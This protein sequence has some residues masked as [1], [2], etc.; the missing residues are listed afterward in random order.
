MSER[1]ELHSFDEKIDPKGGGLTTIV[2]LLVSLGFLLAA[3]ASAGSAL[4]QSE[5]PDGPVYIVQPGDT[6]YTIALRFGVTVEDL[7]EANDLSPDDLIFVGDRILIPG[8][9]GMTGVLDTVTVPFGESLRSL[10]RRHQIPLDKLIKL[11]R[12]TSPGELYAGA[13]LVLP[14]TAGEQIQ[15]TRT[16]LGSGQTALELAVLENVNPWELAAFNGLSNPARALPGDV[17]FVPNR[18]PDGPGGF[19]APVTEVQISDAYQG[20]TFTA[21]IQAGEG[22][23]F[24][25]TLGPYEFDFF[26]DGQGGYFAL[27]GIHPLFEPG[28]VPL[29]ISG[30]LANG[31]RFAHTQMVRVQPRGYAFETLTV[32][33]DLIDPETTEAEWEVVQPYF[34]TITS[35]KM[36]T[37]VFQS[38]SPFADCINSSFGNR[39]SYNGSAFIYYHGGVDFCGGM[40]V[41]VIAPARG[42]VIFAD[43]LE[44]RGNF[45]LIDH[46]WGVLSAYLHQSE[47]FVQVGDMV[48]PGQ[49]IGLVGATGRVT[50]AHLHWEMWVGG[51]QVN[52]LDWLNLPYP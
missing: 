51:I 34:N 27:Q 29:T 52:P 3:L 13:S 42:R 31:A 12:L 22:A 5:E 18:E 50:G 9:E 14:Q 15:T 25:G 41:E 32:S 49:V 40:G 7:L 44:V 45:T 21:R 11:N 23:T 2:L 26:P 30:Q 37:G 6:L 46:G 10:S 17:L 36:W 19:P 35:E 38:P 39:R 28:M 1:R 33:P 24:Q 48:E 20:E 4:A 47:L 8:L 43:Q 16:I